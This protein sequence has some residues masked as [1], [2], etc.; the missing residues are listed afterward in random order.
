MAEHYRGF[1]SKGRDLKW[2]SATTAL[3]LSSW[4]KLWTLRN[5][6]RHR[7]GLESGNPVAKCQ[8]LRKIIQ[9]YELQE[10]RQIDLQWIYNR[11][12]ASIQTWSTYMMRAWIIIYGPILLEGYNK[13]LETG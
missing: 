7:K 12:L 3:M 2:S 9:L 4:W 10:T 11:L 1:D 8:V 5:E 13:A 6:D